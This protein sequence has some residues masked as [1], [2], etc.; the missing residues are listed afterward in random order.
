MK[1]SIFPYVLLSF[2]SS[3]SLAQVTYITGT[4]QP[5]SKVS[6]PVAKLEFKAN[7]SKQ[8]VIYT[9]ERIDSKEISSFAESSCSVID[10]DNWNCADAFAINGKAFKRDK[11]G[12]DTHKCYFEKKLLGGWQPTSNGA[13]PKTQQSKQTDTTTAIN[14]YLIA[15]LKADIFKASDCRM[16]L[17]QVNPV[18]YRKAHLDDAV[19][20]LELLY[21]NNNEVMRMLSTSEINSFKNS[22]GVKI[23][24]SIL[25]ELGASPSASKCGMVTAAIEGQI[26]GSRARLNAK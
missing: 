16:L 20:F 25:D 21:A 1:F 17:K 23:S 10:K 11:A 22:V 4:S 14:S 19:F 18:F 13:P 15:S 5:C 24:Q 6:E 3:S 12:E 7:V 2:I 9:V 8:I 26:D